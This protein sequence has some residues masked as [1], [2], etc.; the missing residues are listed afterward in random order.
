MSGGKT[1]LQVAAH[2]GHQALVEYL[3]S[4]GANV[5][6]VDK[7]GDSVLHYAAFG[8]QPEIM[9]ILLQHGANINVL[10]ASH[11]TAL[12]IS[13]HKKPPHCVRV[14]L[15]FNADVN[16]QDSYGDTALHDAIGKEN[17]EVV[18]LLCGVGTLDLTIRNK[19]GFNCLHHASLKGNVVAARRILQL[20]RQ[21]VD[22]KK[23]DGFS[24]LH[25]AAL[26]GHSVVCEVLV[27]EGQADIDIRNDRRQTPFLLAVSQGH[28][29]AIEKLV[30][31][32]CD[33]LAKD[34]DGDNAMHLTIIKKANLVQEVPQQEAP[35]IFE[36]YQQLTQVQ[37]H[38]LMYTLL[39]YL[40]QEGCKMD[41]NYKGARIFDWIP[42][43][44][45]R[46]LILSY[47]QKRPAAAAS[48]SNDVNQPKELTELYNNIEMLNLTSQDS[49]TISTEQDNSGGSS[50][51]ANF[52]AGSNPP[53]PARRNRGASNNNN[54]DVP[55][56]PPANF[57]SMS[58]EDEKKL[59]NM[60]R[61]HTTSP[62]LPPQ[63]PTTSANLIEASSSP[64]RN[65][66][67]SPPLP[68][69]SKHISRKQQAPKGFPQPPVPP[70][71]VKP[72]LQA[73]QECIVCN[74]ICL[75]ITFEPCYHQICC[76]DCGLR[77]KKCLQCH[78]VIDKRIAM[79][80]K[81]LFPKE[82]P[83]QPSADRLR[84]LET[85]IMEIEETHCC[86][87]C[88]ERKRNVAFLCGHSAC[89]KC[90]ETLK[91]CHM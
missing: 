46:E 5:N 6:I 79:N 65:T 10:N 91:T 61:N 76:E 88:M 4:I 56:P 45:I 86:S 81:L 59:N 54:R 30:E 36:I 27:K 32:K 68:T 58:A 2:Q 87:I 47:E 24:A 72:Q 26:N 60:P 44:E 85:K 19:R 37:E 38:R 18:E 66:S 16:L 71:N 12:H 15:E 29:S 52:N 42:E 48:G 63:E 83:R 53:T 82:N 1:C 35:K 69:S 55:T 25:L 64:N 89:S 11:C 43:A 28:A 13:A 77:M 84:Y 22:V 39:C 70:F 34:E 75:M 33:I 49:T 74:E 9:R 7:E 80:G 17:T 90:A 57:S 67:Q 23:D 3:L 62:P 78:V 50:S 51:M 41:A 14:L 31:L 21:L 8:N 20:A 73:P 40:A